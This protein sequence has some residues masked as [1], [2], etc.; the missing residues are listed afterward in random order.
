[1][2]TL[3]FN[4]Q[5]SRQTSPAMTSAYELGIGRAREILAEGRN[6]QDDA[7]LAEDSV[8]L[9]RALL[10]ASNA[11][12]EPNERERADR[13]SALL[14]DPVG[15]AFVSALTDRAH[16][17]TS[18]AR[19]VEEVE[20]LV[21][22]LGVPRS[23]SGW[24][25]VELRALQVFGS[26]VP[27]LT[28]RAVR[29]RIYEDAAPYL[30]PADPEKLAAFLRER[31]LQG[32]S[33]NVNHLGEEVLGNHDAERYLET[34][35]ALLARPEVTTI[36]V[37][38]SS[39]DSRVDVVAWDATQ[40]R[41]AEKLALIYRAALD[42]PHADAPG[43][44]EPKLVYL[45]M[46]AYRD[47]E[48]TT[49]LFMRVLDRPELSR[50]TAG[51]VLQ[52]YIPD[53]HAHQA[54]LLAWARQRV[55]RGGAPIRMRLVKGANLMMERIEASQRGFELATYPN[56]P[57]VDASFRRMLREGTTFEN[58]RAVRLGVGSHN[59]FD[60]AYTL[61]LRERR[62][63]SEWVEPEMLEGM[64]DPLRRV[65]QRVAGRVL[66]Y[67]PS[68]DARD[69]PT[70]VAY[71]VRRLDENTSEENFLRHSF[72]MRAGDASFEA[73]RRRFVEA[74]A[75]SERV[76]TEPFRTQDRT[77]EPLPVAGA[78][79]RNEPDT[80][81]SQRK[82]R[83][84]LL[85]HLERARDQK[86]CWVA[87]RVEGS[88]LDG[89]EQDGFDPSRPGFVPY[90][91]RKL[92]RQEVVRAIER[93]HA[94]R[95]SFAE[96]PA[97]RREEILGAV[98]QELRRARGELIGAMVLDAG[99]RPIEADAEVSEAID[100]A[101]YYAHQHERLRSRFE[102][103][104]KGLVVVTPP[105]NFPLSIGLG[106]TL[107]A[108]VAGNPVLLKPPPETP[109]VLARAVELCLRAG[110]PETALG[111]VIASD[112]DAEPL[113]TDPRVA[114][115]MLTGGTETAKLF[116]RLRPDLD[117]IAE[118]GGKNAMIVGA[119]S[120]RE[121]AVQHAVRSAFGH[122]GQ[123]CSALS[124][125]IVERE[126]YRSASFRKKLA[127]AVTSLAV[128]SAWD[129]ETFVTPLIRPPSGPLLRALETLD[130]G[131]SWLVEP[132]RSRDNERSVGPGVRWDV[133]PGSFAH[134]TELFGP[135]LAVVE[136]LDFDHALDIANGTP[137]GL[138]A[139]LESLDAREHAAFLER[140]DAGNL[141]VNRPTTGAI[142]GRQPF[143]GHKASSFGRGFKAGGPNTLLALTHVRAERGRAVPAG[144]ALSRG[145]RAP[146]AKSKP[147]AARRPPPDLGPLGE[148]VDDRLRDAGRPEQERLARRMKSYEA[149]LFDEI[150][151]VHA[152]DEVLGHED[153]FVYRP[154]RMAVVVLA[155]SEEL[156]LLC[157]LVAAHMVGAEIELFAEEGAPSAIQRM[158]GEDPLFFR[159]LEELEAPLV[160]G[161]FERLRLLGTEARAASAR[162]TSAAPSLD[163]DPVS[164]S[165]YVE[166][167]RYV[168]EQ[169]RSIARHRHGNL[170]LYL[171]LD[172]KRA[173]EPGA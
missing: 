41:L 15:Q 137:Y 132:A 68:V 11:G 125:L 167:R 94:A 129:L 171:A 37:K 1:M 144:P 70:A 115:V 92:S 114:A 21:A 9:A 29:R 170:S 145:P 32:L 166:L 40:A 48:L 18:G 50:L 52:A 33:V 24:D 123:K 86:P 45:D 20:G 161:R 122:A 104:P 95:V 67:A 19:L 169:S 16:R 87:S 165:G 46:E 135:V 78:G 7:A 55:E 63:V 27:E 53:S 126:V 109:L 82:N 117:L 146:A 124:L 103:E 119:M 64:A 43:R 61:L 6:A 8:E 59:L 118:T 96:T 13:I 71:L 72:G 154:C 153:S 91:V 85:S 84:W 139:G 148:I 81:F 38:L 4:P 102:L 5:R 164:E 172:A 110:V 97:G 65:V 99:K 34:Y 168:S 151:V 130:T 113:I 83:E 89:V 121:Q 93:A 47:L 157:T 10:E 152:A 31:S 162:L 26:A 23:L 25:R 44:G 160:E 12:S 107:A 76:G 2:P 58:A 28:A 14:S 143:G 100:F 116:R 88:E 120:D 42:H 134:T 30:A 69:F 77:R 36:S 74:L 112:D 54:R 49:E 79:F 173:T 155:G 3:V 57:E 101:E 128:G 62:G 90:R 142:V 39:I 159:T 17:S 156:D 35:L 136:A 141:Y 127:D 138:T 80:D 98:A 149:A 105:W 140:M 60:I 66:V 56:K 106:S 158:L 111:L 108:L 131:E 150:D 51:I 22:G 147:P 163:A 75:A 73:E 133:Q